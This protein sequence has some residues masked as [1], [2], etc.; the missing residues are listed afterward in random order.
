MNKSDLIAALVKKEN[1]TEKMAADI[2]NLIFDSFT[3]EMK[4][5]AGSKSEA[6]GSL[7]C[8]NTAPIKAGT[9][10][11]ERHR[12]EAQT[13]AAF[14]NRQRI[15]KE[16]GWKINK[17]GF[18]PTFEPFACSVLISG[19]SGFPAEVEAIDIPATL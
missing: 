9:P 13:A 15:E 1:M 14:Q 2:V 7:R 6:W 18:R 5:A 16:G 12:R 3:N 17:A 8:G 10:R 19:S 4:Q 11:P